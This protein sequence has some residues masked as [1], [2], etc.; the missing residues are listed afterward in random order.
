MEKSKAKFRIGE[1]V[2]S[3]YDNY[4]LEEIT[5]VYSN[6]WGFTY[7]LQGRKDRYHE[8]L[9]TNLFDVGDK[10][11]AGSDQC[12][13]T[14]KRILYH[15]NSYKMEDGSE[16][17][18]EEVF[19]SPVSSKKDWILAEFLKGHEGE[20]FYHLLYE[21]EVKL[22]NINLT[23]TNEV[24]EDGDSIFT[25]SGIY[26]NLGENYGIEYIRIDGRWDSSGKGLIL[27]YPSR[28]LYLK[29]PLDPVKAWMTWK[30]GLSSKE[31]ELKVSV[32]IN[33]ESYQECIKFSSKKEVTQILTKIKEFFRNL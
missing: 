30:N 5:E 22:T 28:E 11:I 10:V 27:L 16:Y 26:Y 14:I 25:P 4:S 32:N 29:Y 21:K 15:K 33:E 13:K 20:T 3:I 6:S 18:F 24:D 7:S 19:K 17:S 23:D 31:Y 12:I 8:S 9:L 2:F 1:K